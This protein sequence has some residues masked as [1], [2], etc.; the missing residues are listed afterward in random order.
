[1]TKTL[2]QLCLGLMMIPTLLW[3][4]PSRALKVMRVVDGDTL[5]LSNGERVRLVGVDTPE[6]HPSRKLTRDSQRTGRDEKSIRSM[7][8]QASEFVKKLVENE[9]VTLQFDHSNAV[10]GHRD[11]YGRTLAYVYFKPK[12]YQNP[13]SWLDKDVYLSDLYR[14]GFLNAIIIYSGYSQAYTNFPFDQMDEF[15]DYAKSARDAR[16]GLWKEE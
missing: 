13:P 5:L 10:K 12:R 2:P 6:V 3:G 1:M 9:D 8:K 4:E 14:R 15:R 16:R 11:R 7:G